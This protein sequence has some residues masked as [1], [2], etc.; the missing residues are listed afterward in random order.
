VRLA[1]AALASSLVLLPGTALAQEAETGNRR[2]PATGMIA[3]PSFPMP[4]D[5][6]Y[7][8]G[9]MVR[10]GPEKP[11]G[12]PAGF[13]TPLRLLGRLEKA[14]VPRTNVKLAI[15][16]SGT[17]TH[18]LLRDDAYRAAKGTANA[19]VAVLDRLQAA[20]VQVIVCGE[21]LFNRKVPRNGLH[22][23]VKVAPDAGLARIALEAQGYTVYAED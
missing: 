8:I 2:D 5:L 9:W 20:G 21:A 22:P 16:V 11:D 18:S 10:T 12:V 14:G 15:V 6:T 17:A 1:L 3:D 23:W 7:R 4:K 13:E 19:S